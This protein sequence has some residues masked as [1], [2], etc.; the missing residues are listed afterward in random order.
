MVLKNPAPSGGQGFEKP[1]VRGGNGFEKLAEKG[2]LGSENRHST[3][4]YIDCWRIAMKRAALCLA[5]ALGVSF[6]AFA[7]TTEAELRL[8]VPYSSMAAKIP[9]LTVQQ[10]NEAIREYA[11]SL[12]TRPAPSYPATTY[13]PPTRRY[14]APTRPSIT[15]NRA[16]STTFYDS[17][18]G[19][20]GTA[21]RLGSTTFYNYSDGTFG[22]SNRLGSTTF[23]NLNNPRG[24]SLNGTTNRLGTTEFHNFS[25]GVSGTSSQIGGT[26]FHNFSDGT[27]CTSSR[28]GRTTFTN[29]N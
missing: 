24:G 7:Q 25:N 28:I 8:A 9:G 4:P 19:V 1:H 15:E 20:T 18:D 17:S 21:N 11:R 16:G 26:T 3:I 6:P 22:T 2:S 14:V 12:N 29:C 27:S 23:H 10:Y 13:Q 5:F